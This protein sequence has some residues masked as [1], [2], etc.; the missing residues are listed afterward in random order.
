M[1]KIFLIGII[2]LML[3]GCGTADKFEAKVTGY[4]KKC[5]DNVIYLQF[6]SGATVA[7]NVDGSI[8]TCE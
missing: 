1:K 3:S 6:A 5:I 7:Y 2:G 8:K 4:S